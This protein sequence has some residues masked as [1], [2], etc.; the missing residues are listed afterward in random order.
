MGV[1]LATP[2]YIIYSL[3]V[4]TFVYVDIV[5]SIVMLVKLKQW[6]AF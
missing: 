5:T 3:A 2:L 6:H 1:I 4:V